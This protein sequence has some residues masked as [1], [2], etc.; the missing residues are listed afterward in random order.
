M[1]VKERNFKKIGIISV[2]TAILLFSSYSINFIVK[3]EEVPPVD[4]DNVVIISED[5]HKVKEIVEDI[6]KDKK[7][8]AEYEDIQDKVVSNEINIDITASEDSPKLEDSS[9]IIADATEIKENKSYKEELQEGLEEGKRV[10]LY[11]DIKAD[12]Y[13]EILDVEELSVDD[14]DGGEYLFGLTKE[15]LNQKA[16]EEGKDA[17]IRAD[18]DSLE[19]TDSEYVSHIIGYTL[20]DNK[21]MQY[22]ETTV[23]NFDENGNPIPNTEESLIKSAMNIQTNIIDSEQEKYND[24]IQEQEE[25]A[26]LPFLKDNKVSAANKRVLNVYGKKALTAEAK[27]LGVLVGEIH[28]DYHLY[29]ETDDDDKKYDFFTLKPITQIDSYK[30]FWAKSLSVDI[31]IPYDSDHLDSWSPMGDKG[32]K[33]FNVGL[34][35][36]FAISLAMDFGESLTIDDQSS[37]KYDYARWLLKDH[38]TEINT[39]ISGET[40]N[41]V[42]GWASTGTMATVGLTVEGKFD[43]YITLKTKKT[44]TYNY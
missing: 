18:K 36:P 10:I 32:G 40:F 39:N 23:H 28:T 8:E 17:V 11:G 35:Y 6:T 5:E 20:D 42:A 16:K 3:A 14:K 9:T 44:I 43:N 38:I 7:I 15:E 21:E 13:K 29:K 31:D 33:S 12:E 41:P 27:R 24:A 25:V 1:F 30:G 4:E 37:L 26:F 19:D 2:L 34:S 22:V